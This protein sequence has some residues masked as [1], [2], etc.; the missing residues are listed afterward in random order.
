MHSYASAAVVRLDNAVAREFRSDLY[1]RLHV[2]P[3]TVPP[4]REHPEDIPL[5]IRY[6]A[7]HYARR[8]GKPR[9]DTRGGPDDPLPLLQNEKARHLPPHLTP[10]SQHLPIFRRSRFGTASSLQRTLPLA[11]AQ[12]LVQF[13]LVS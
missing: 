4:L 5:L 1:Y 3:I 6:F 7:Q 13:Q 2:F 10:I 8:M 12:N 11:K 9:G